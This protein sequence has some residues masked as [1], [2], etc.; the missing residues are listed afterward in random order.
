MTSCFIHGLDN[1]QEMFLSFLFPL[2]LICQES[3]RTLRNERDRPPPQKNEIAHEKK[4]KKR[5]K[6]E[7]KTSVD[8]LSPRIGL[9]SDDIIGHAWRIGH[10]A[11]LLRNEGRFYINP[12]TNIILIYRF[13]CI[14]CHSCSIW[15]ISKR[16]PKTVNDTQRVWDSRYAAYAI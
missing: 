14:H 5:R 8:E 11:N 2:I 15:G 7:K 3:K 9:V 13:S 4:E 16:N 6:T 10:L 1:K 12:S